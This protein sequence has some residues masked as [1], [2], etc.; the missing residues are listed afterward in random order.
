MK[1]LLSLL[2]LSGFLSTIAFAQSNC[3]NIIPKIE[4]SGNFIPICDGT[5][6]GLPNLLTTSDLP[7]TEFVIIN[8][9]QPATDG[10][11]MMIMGTDE[12]GESLPTDLG[13][14]FDQR[15]SMTPVAYDLSAFRSWVDILLNNQSGVT[16]C[17]ELM[18]QMS[19]D[20]CNNMSA[21]SLASTDINNLSDVFMV[22]GL[23]NGTTG[24]A[25]LEGR[26]QQIDAFK[27]AI[28]S[29]PTDCKDAQ[30][31]LCYAAGIDEQLYSINETP[32]IVDV[33]TPAP[34]QV[35]IIA[36]VSN[37]VLEYS[38]DGMTWQSSNAFFNATAIGVAYTRLLSTG[39][40]EQKEY[41]NT[42]LSV[43]LMYF[44]GEVEATTN[45]LTWATAT[46]SGNAAFIVER[47]ADGTNFDEIERVPGAINSQSML[48]YEYRDANPFSDIGYY[49]LIMEDVD[50]YLTYS[51]VITVERDDPTGFS[52]L[53][54][55]PNP[56]DRVINVSITNGDPGNMDF[57]IYDVMGR[58][59]REGS[60]EIHTGLNNFPIDAIG[61]GTSVYIFT[62]SKGD[63]VV[64]AY[65]FMMYS[66]D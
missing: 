16:T 21:A 62:A 65:K 6:T 33:E 29:L 37:G 31:S 41:E 66:K 1:K 50:G 58:K 5:M 34:R 42:N 45:G 12:N 59:V 10:Q 48:V 28:E 32:V 40:I 36:N 64:S 18:A 53:S 3:G 7:D 51:N 47:S 52:I 43:E 14:T 2:V 11:G 8:V 17:C 19:A 23:F 30:T 44:K 60:Q 55:G 39:C 56:S 61:L 49:R 25:S 15:F 22:L 57:T 54:I 35:V 46:E 38:L 63:Y 20:F 9:D 4:T 26:L 13:M 27:T 24:S